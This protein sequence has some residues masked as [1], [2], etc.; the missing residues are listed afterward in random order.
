MM[1][2]GKFAYTFLE[3]AFK[4]QTKAIEDQGRKQV[5]V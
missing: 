1:K 5:E 4:K 2:Q 3:K